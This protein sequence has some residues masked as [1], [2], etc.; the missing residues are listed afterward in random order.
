MG[1]KAH[2]EFS[3]VEL[4]VYLK[5]FAKKKKNQFLVIA[6]FCLLA[7]FRFLIFVLFFG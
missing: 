1:E 7:S 4:L 5:K 6:S 3:A 2:S